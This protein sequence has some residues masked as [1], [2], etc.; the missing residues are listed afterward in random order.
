MRPSAP[1]PIVNGG[2][3]LVAEGVSIRL[4]SRTIIDGFHL[5]HGPGTVAWLVGENGGGKSTLLGVLARLTKPTAGEVRHV[6]QDGD[7]PGVAYYHTEMHLPPG[8]RCRDWH[9][10]AR[11]LRLPDPRNPAIDPPLAR[12]D[13]L[14]QHLSTGEE[15][16][17]I[18]EAI[19][20]TGRPFLFLDEPFEHL[21][22][23][24]KEVLAARL[25]SLARDRV[26]VVAT[27]Q[28]IPPAL[29]GGAVVRLTPGA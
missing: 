3:R 10:L 26:V 8:V 17:V 13:V 16:R 18:L 19:L 20:S 28:G 24:G 22:P 2:P 27:N 21:S 29:E 1:P 14:A 11:R 12:P 15:K 23:E 25:A 9:V 6:S 5:D 7:R 4:G